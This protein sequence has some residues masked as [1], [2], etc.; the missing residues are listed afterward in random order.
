[1]AAEFCQPNV[2]RAPVKARPVVE[3][4]QHF[5]KKLVEIDWIVVAL[6]LIS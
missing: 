2:N 4:K 3:L 1:M 6:P 5:A